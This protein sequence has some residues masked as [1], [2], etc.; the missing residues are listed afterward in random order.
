MLISGMDGMGCKSLNIALV[1]TLERKQRKSQ[2]GKEDEPNAT[3]PRRWTTPQQRFLFKTG[4]LKQADTF[5]DATKRSWNNNDAPTPIK[6]LKSPPQSMG[7]QDDETL[8]H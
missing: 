3:S 5:W 6:L 7:C 1:Q 4:F 2:G 8:H